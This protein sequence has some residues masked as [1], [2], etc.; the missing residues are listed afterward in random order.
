MKIK[1]LK[2]WF[3]AFG[4]AAILFTS[5]EKTVEEPEITANNLKGMFVVGAFSCLFML[6]SGTIE[7]EHTEI[8][9]NQPITGL[10]SSTGVLF[11]A[12]SP[13]TVS[14][15]SSTFSRLTVV[16][17]IILGLRGEQLAN[18]PR[19]SPERVLV[20]NSKPFDLSK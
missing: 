18:T 13:V 4:G 7:Y 2:K 1:S 19:N 12:S 17:P 3:I 6:I 15:L 20:C 5:C 8:N 11:N 9:K 14:V 10:I 16:R